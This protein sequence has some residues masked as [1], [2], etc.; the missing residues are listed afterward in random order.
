MNTSH[1][2][3][4]ITLDQPGW[5]QFPPT[6]SE[7]ATIPP[8]AI[9]QLNKS[10]S[11]RIFSLPARKLSIALMMDWTDCVKSAFRNGSISASSRRPYVQVKSRVAAMLPDGIFAGEVTMPF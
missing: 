8:M 2:P 4:E 3:R 6:R 5:H 11:E 10:D 7:D 9:E 1:T